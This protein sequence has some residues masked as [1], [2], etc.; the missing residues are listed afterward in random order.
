MSAVLAMRRA[1]QRSGDSEQMALA[2]G[3]QLQ[4]AIHSAM[5]VVLIKSR[6]NSPRKQGSAP[7]AQACMS[8]PRK[9]ARNIRVA[10]V[11]F[12]HLI[13]A[14]VVQHNQNEICFTFIRMARIVVSAPLRLTYL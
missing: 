11:G 12:T 3:M 7:S 6:A 1:R 14:C 4:H 5:K 2:G 8:D 10:L 9:V 13:P